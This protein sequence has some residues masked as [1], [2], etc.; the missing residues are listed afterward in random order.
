MSWRQAWPRPHRENENWQRWRWRRRVR[1]NRRRSESHPRRVG[2]ERSSHGRHECGSVTERPASAFQM[3]NGCLRPSEATATAA[4]AVEPLAAAAVADS[5]SVEQLQMCTAAEDGNGCGG[6]GGRQRGRLHTAKT[7]TA[8]ACCGGATLHATLERGALTEGNWQ[9]SADAL[10]ASEKL[11]W[12]RLVYGGG[13]PGNRGMGDARARE[14]VLAAVVSTAAGVVGAVVGGRGGRH[15]GARRGPT[16]TARRHSSARRQTAQPMSGAATTCSRVRLS[17]GQGGWRVCAGF[18]PFLV[19]HLQHPWRWQRG[20]HPGRPSSNFPA[21]SRRRP[22]P[23]A[24]PQ[25]PAR[26][27]LSGA[28][29]RRPRG[30]CFCRLP[31]AGAPR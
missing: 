22:R 25:P 21:P 27:H 26:P 1:R 13:A 8:A 23:R 3:L 16:V 12:L 14:G 18:C 17:P 28:R 20:P 6:F 4:A 24:S 15:G 2:W 19:Y 10:V 5:V 29:L 9:R 30:R 11:E 7:A 31:A